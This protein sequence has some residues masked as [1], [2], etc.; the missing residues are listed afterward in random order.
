MRNDFKSLD[1]IKKLQYQS[2]IDYNIHKYGNTLI[3]NK[4]HYDDEEKM[5][6]KTHNIK[7]RT[8]A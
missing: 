1:T 6:T 7:H 5:K 3:H 2:E 4:Y 8:F